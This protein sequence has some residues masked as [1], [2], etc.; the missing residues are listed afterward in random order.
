[1][2]NRSKRKFLKDIAAL[3]FYPVI[4]P[5]SC[6]LSGK[7]SEPFHGTNKNKLGVALVGL[8]YYST[9]L[10]APA[11]QITSHCRLS[12]IVTGSPHKIPKW[13]RR[14]NIPDSNIYNYENMHLIADNPDIDVIYI[15]VP[16]GLHK[17]YGVIAAETGKH[18]WCEKPM[19]MNVAEC[20]ELIKACQKN[21]VK[22]SIGY[23]MQHEPNMQEVIQLTKDGIFGS[24]K[25]VSASAGYSGG[26]GTGWRFQKALGGGALYDMG[27]YTINAIR[28][29]S[30]MEPVR[31]LEA[32]HSTTRP[33]AFHEVDE[34]TE[35]TLELPQGVIASG[36]T[37]VGKSINRLEVFCADGSYYLAPMQTY[38]GVRGARSDGKRININVRNQQALQMD[39][40]ALAIINDLP[41]LVP[42]ED[43]KED[44]RILNAIQQ[45]AI[46]KSP[47]DIV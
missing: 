47:I 17:K 2:K 32:K 34:T 19:A 7:S 33:K 27:V 16:T 44:I 37:S 43:G 21:G 9:D 6:S 35:Y 11:L 4:H 15:V 18:V 23:R 14:Y 25:S 29:A 46:L 20:E 40:D 22:L 41:V 38:N 12:G 8:G 39:H 45:S 26:T 24:V 13:Q 36:H 30:Q 1:M 31:V 10:L 3:S 5:F 42:G 28:H